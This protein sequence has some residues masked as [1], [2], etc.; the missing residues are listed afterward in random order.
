LHHQ[1][2][3]KVAEFARQSRAQGL[4]VV[5]VAES[6]Q[7]QEVAARVLD[8]RQGGSGSAAAIF[9]I[10]SSASPRREAGAEAMPPAEPG[11]ALPSRRLGERLLTGKGT[12]STSTGVLPWP[13]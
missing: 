7:L 3:G 10:G 4:G 13:R 12:L 6:A 11:A 5:A 8:L 1:L 2:A 9:A